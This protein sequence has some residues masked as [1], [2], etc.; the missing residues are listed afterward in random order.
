MSNKYFWYN[1]IEVARKSDIII[2]GLTI[3]FIIGDKKYL[4]PD[5]TVADN[6]IYE[7]LTEIINYL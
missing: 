4:N 6:S 3:P 1:L 5:F 7:L 2:D